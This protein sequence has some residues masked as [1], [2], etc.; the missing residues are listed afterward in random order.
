MGLLTQR[1]GITLS[2]SPSCEVQQKADPHCRKGMVTLLDLA[3]KEGH[4]P[5]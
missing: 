4:P 5:L 3:E 1:R 2:L